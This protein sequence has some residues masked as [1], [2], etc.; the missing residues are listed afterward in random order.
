MYHKDF[1]LLCFLLKMPKRN[2]LFFI[3]KK[4]PVF[5]WEGNTG[6]SKSQ[7][8]YTA[9]NPIAWGKLICL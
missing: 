6:E 1:S 8:G 2:A 5:I 4:Y 9:H 3:C 7:W